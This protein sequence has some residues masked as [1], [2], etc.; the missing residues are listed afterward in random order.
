M[1]AEERATEEHQKVAEREVVQLVALA[2]K[3]EQEKEVRQAT[4]KAKRKRLQAEVKVKEAVKEVA[5]ASGLVASGLKRHAETP[6]DD[7]KEVEEE[8]PVKKKARVRRTIS[9][10]NDE[11][12]LAIQPCTQ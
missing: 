3:Q 1:K 8:L 9:V 4:Q 2:A 11:V 10:A 5:S 6:S 7:N 12:P